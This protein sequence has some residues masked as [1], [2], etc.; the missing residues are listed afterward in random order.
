M[1]PGK[2]SPLIAA[3]CAFAAGVA[4]GQGYDVAVEDTM[5]RVRIDVPYTGADAKAGAL[6][7]RPHLGS[8]PKPPSDLKLP[9]P[10]GLSR[11][12]RISAAQGE[13][14]GFQAVIM[15]TDTDLSDVTLSASPL[16]LVDG[17]STIAPARFTFHQVGYVKTARPDYDV[18]RTG[19]FA[20]PLLNPAQF[21]V[22][23]GDVQPVWITIRVPLGIP[24]GTYEGNVFVKSSNAEKKAI[25]VRLR[26]W[27]FAIPEAGSQLKMAFNWDEAA[28]AAIYGQADWKEKNLKHKYMDCLLEH[29]MGV[30]NIY[31]G[32]PPKVDDLKY[33][34]D[35]GAGSFNLFNVGWPASYTDA[36][37]EATLN[38]IDAVWKQYED[39]GVAD[40]AY[41]F[42]FDEHYQ[43]VAIPQIYGAIGKKFPKLK[44][45]VSTGPRGKPADAHADIW[46]M[47]LGTYFAAMKAGH[48]ERLQPKGVQF[49]L[50]LSTSAGP[51]RPNWW[52][53]SPLIESR[54]LFWLAYQ[55]DADG[56]LYYFINHSEGTPS[57]ID[58]SGGAYT[59]WNPR[60]FPG[61][62]GDGQLIYASKNGP[63]A[64]VRMANIRDGVEDHEYFKLLE[65]LL[66]E[67]GKVKNRSEAQNYIKGQFVRYVGVN[68]W[69]HTHEA[70][71]LRAVRDR[72]AEE[73][74]KLSGTASSPNGG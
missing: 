43:E 32:T 44:R 6:T 65:R 70:E 15:A 51:P 63:L 35:R 56:C 22:K 18:E 57:P 2:H 72:V 5:R 46:A 4:T 62:N 10:G 50:Y 33:A 39:A 61:H 25:P 7:V 34:V 45:L 11:E 74:D 9:Q 48:I 60:T 67:K 12:V 14:E 24:A 30:D 68:F 21:N 54:S 55:V 1:K 17:K 27:G 59:K 13:S 40:T 31:R 47:S 16:T 3:F 53:E 69:I 42:G 36:Q 58:E 38:R 29:R 73:I 19:W 49:W 71:L 23:K 26:V 37:V 28:S 52:I 41:I 66:V 8:L 64:S 20:D